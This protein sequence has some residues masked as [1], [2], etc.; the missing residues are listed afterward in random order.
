MPLTVIKLMPDKRKLFVDVQTEL[1]NRGLGADSIDL[2][3]DEL[4]EHPAKDTFRFIDGFEE[5]QARVVPAFSRCRG[6]DDR[7]LEDELFVDPCEREVR[8]LSFVEGEIVI[9]SR[10]EHSEIDEAN[11]TI[12]EPCRAFVSKNESLKLP[13]LASTVSHLL[14]P[15][16]VTRHLAL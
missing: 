14:P 7:R 1:R 4:R 9:D 10:T 12:S 3:R 6:V 13:T 2:D 11:V 8:L 15:F 16:V 5:S